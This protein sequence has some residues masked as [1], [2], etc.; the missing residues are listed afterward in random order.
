MAA[1][2]GVSPGGG[3][4]HAH[5]QGQQDSGRGSRCEAQVAEGSPLRL[6][7]VGRSATSSA[8]PLAVLCPYPRMPSEAPG[9]SATANLQRRSQ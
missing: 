1:M 6:S 7:P 2:E 8:L 4:H 5:S 3:G 9:L